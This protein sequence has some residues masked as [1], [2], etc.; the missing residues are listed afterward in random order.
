M[1]RSTPAL[2]GLAAA[3]AL[4]AA[5]CSTSVARL[6][7][8]DHRQ[9]LNVPVPI[10]VTLKAKADPTTFTASIDGRDVTDAFVFED[11]RGV[12]TGHVYEAAPPR[13][14][15]TLTI[16]AEPGV[17]AKGRPLGRSFTGTLTY[18]P[19]ALSLQGNV[20]M[21][22]NSRV[23]LPRDGRTSVMVRLPQPTRGAL[24]LT[25]TPAD[26]KGVVLNDHAPGE[27]ITVELEPG[28][29]VAVFTVRG[30]RPGVGTLR[31]EAPG[32][33]AAELPTL[34]DGPTLTAAVATP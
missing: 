3:A 7:G 32:Y 11:G 6:D 30:H 22:V 23:E 28:R 2:F 17:N 31:V 14:P 10:A 19:P 34:I 18:F 16:A 33:V 1:N 20:G 13:Q 12:L 21:G 9:R 4:A 24:T 8:P 29:R 5:G 15:H 27:P 25:V 26:D